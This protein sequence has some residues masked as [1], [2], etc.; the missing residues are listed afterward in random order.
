MNDAVLQ[1]LYPLHNG[2]AFGLAGRIIIVIIGLAP[3]LLY[4]SGII[5]WQQKR[6]AKMKR[7]ARQDGRPINIGF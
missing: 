5:R 2:E 7:L 6:D 4:V 1:W 3:L